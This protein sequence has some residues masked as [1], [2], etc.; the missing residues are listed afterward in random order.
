MSRTDILVRVCLVP[1]RVCHAA[2]T[3]PFSQASMAK[4]PLPD[5]VQML[6]PARAVR[7]MCC[8]DRMY[9]HLCS[10]TLSTVESLNST[11]AAMLT[12]RICSACAMSLTRP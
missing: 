10:H 7:R 2:V 6:S 9:M 8:L 3:D 1:V 4:R 5:A 11:L 12:G